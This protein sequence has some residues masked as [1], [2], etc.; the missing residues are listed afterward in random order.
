VISHRPIA[1]LPD[2]L[3]RNVAWRAHGRQ[4]APL[5]ALAL[6]LLL[7][8]PGASAALD[9]QAAAALADAAGECARIKRNKDRLACFDRAAKAAGISA[10]AADDPPSTAGS[11]TGA[12]ASDGGDAAAV[13]GGAGAATASAAAAVAGGENADATRPEDFGREQIERRQPDKDKQDK[14]LEQI[15]AVV[16]QI[17]ERGD[18]LLV[19]TLENGQVWRQKSLT[20]LFRVREGDS[21]VIRKG[22]F[23]G[24]T[25]IAPGRRSTQVT[26]LK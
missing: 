15:E 7:T 14:K 11:A 13:A 17:D 20:P 24:Y 21:V 9:A 1:T 16:T 12:T 4:I 3:L 8:T 26:R 22:T 18:D 25:L 10:D 2:H 19:F 5:G 23:G 6:I